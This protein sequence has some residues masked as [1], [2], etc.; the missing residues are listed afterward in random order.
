MRSLELLLPPPV[1]MLTTA[2]IM[3]LL[4]VLFPTFN[5][6]LTNSLIGAVIVGL[7]GLAIGLSG[8]IS[9]LRAKT[10]LD[11]KRPGDASLLVTSGI[12]RFTRNPMYLGLLLMLAAWGMFLG[13]ILSLLFIIVFFFYIHRYQIQPEERVLEEKFGTEFIL[14]KTKVRPWI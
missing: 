6:D 12:Y 3:W 8:A 1:I 14:Y 11:P 2:L 13:N 4:S 7:I 10:T 5:K 9:F